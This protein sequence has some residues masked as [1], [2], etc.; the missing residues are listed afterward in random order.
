MARAW[1]AGGEQGADTV[2]AGEL[3]F[4]QLGAQIVCADRT[5]A[6]AAPS[7]YGMLVRRPGASPGD[8]VLVAMDRST[9]D[10][11]AAVRGACLASEL[12][13]SI[14]ILSADVTGPT[15]SSVSSTWPLR[16]LN[17]ADVPLTVT[18]RRV[19]STTVE[20][21]LSGTVMIAPHTAG[22]VTSRLLLH[23]CSAPGGRVRWPSC[24]TR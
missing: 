4:V 8:D 10:L 18:T 20:T 19:P 22:T 14:S 6:T 23:D 1:L 7:S 15:G 24:R 13:K 9:T 11:G 2:V 3:A 17:D 21:D 5:L 12:P 16:V